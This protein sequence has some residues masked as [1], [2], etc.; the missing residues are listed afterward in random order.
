MSIFNSCTSIPSTY[1]LS[2]ERDYSL[3][4][5]VQLNYF[6]S[7]I[8]PMFILD[9][10]KRLSENFDVGVSFIPSIT[11]YTIAPYIVGSTVIGNSA[12]II[13]FTQIPSRINLNYLLFNDE[14]GL[15][16]ISLLDFHSGINVGINA[17]YLI[18]SQQKIAIGARID[19]T[20]TWITDSAENLF[21]EAGSPYLFNIIYSIPLNNDFVINSI[22]ESD[23]KLN[24]SANSEFV[25]LGNN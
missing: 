3:G 6:N 8:I 11:I 10:R 24:L 2:E 15:D 1:K 14:I 17:Y 22:L 13:C 7:A 25:F 23:T 16:P 21:G 19:S 5:F 9:A 12:Q 4:I 20:R 18:D